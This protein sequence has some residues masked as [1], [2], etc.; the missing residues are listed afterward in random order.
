MLGIRLFPGGPGR[1]TAVLGAD[2]FEGDDG[3]IEAIK[4]Q[5]FTLVRI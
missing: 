2:R 3:R 1:R 4:L 5:P